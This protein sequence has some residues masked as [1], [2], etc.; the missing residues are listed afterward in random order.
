MTRLLTSATFASREKI[1]SLSMNLNAA[2]LPPL[3]S[4]VKMEAPPFGK[5]FSYR[6]WSGCSGRDG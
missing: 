4:K 6:A 5:Y 3:M 2:S 1:W